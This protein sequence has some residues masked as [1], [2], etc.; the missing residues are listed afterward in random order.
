MQPIRLRAKHFLIDMDGVIYR[1][2]KLIEGADEFIARLKAKK[3]RFLFLTNASSKTPRELQA[4][5][6]RLGIEV[7][8]E[9]FYTSALATAA[10]LDAQHPRGKAYV[11]GEKGLVA[12][13]RGVGYQITERRP[14]YVV[15]GQTED[16]SKLKKATQLISQGIP[17]IATNPDVTG[18][19]EDGIEPAMGAIAA[20]IEKATGKT[21]Y[22]IG[23]PNP[24]MMRK[25]LQRLRVHSS[26][27]AIIGDRMDT[28]IVAGV[29]AGLETILVLS[30][31]TCLEDLARYPYRPDLVLRSVA[32]L[33]L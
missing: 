4:K 10:F 7:S 31:V 16:F 2:D 21:A 5:L 20:M 9:C 28:D 6:L 25:A 12:A 18:P 24:L 3:K 19:A 14:D 13:L 11:V 1:G 30:G 26:E 27:T 23:K 33:K 29:E 15:V 17:F 22:F 8:A 32:D